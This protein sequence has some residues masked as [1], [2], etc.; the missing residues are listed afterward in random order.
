MFF[1]V[2][3]VEF[4]DH[5]HAGAAVLDNL[6]GVR[7]LR[8]AHADVGVAQAVGRTLVAIAVKLEVDAAQDAVER[9]DVGCRE[10]RD[11]LA[12]AIAEP[13]RQSGRPRPLPFSLAVSASPGSAAWRGRALFGSCHARLC[14]LL[15]RICGRPS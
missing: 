8:E 13:A 5:L 11:P 15:M 14:S 3:G 7:R 4:L 9:L 6:V 2:C 1:D 10:R 12:P